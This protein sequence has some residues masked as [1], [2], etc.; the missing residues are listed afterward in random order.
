MPG[1]C[2]APPAPAIMTL[3]PLFLACLPYCTILLVVLCADTILT[4]FETPNE[5]K[6]PAASLI[7]ARSESLPMI[8]P[9]R[10]FF[11]FVFVFVLIFIFN[12][13]P[14]CLG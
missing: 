12:F 13:S 3:I 7:T 14:T 11:V 8:M 10:V 9:T 2:A 6:K 5:S 1:R 4:S